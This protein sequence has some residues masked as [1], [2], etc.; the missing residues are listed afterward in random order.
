MASQ[1]W[2]RIGTPGS[3]RDVKVDKCK[4]DILSPPTANPEEQVSS[5]EALTQSVECGD[6]LPHVVVLL[7]VGLEH[8]GIHV[9]AQAEARHLPGVPHHREQVLAA[10]QI[11]LWGGRKVGVKL[12]AT[13]R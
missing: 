5:S 6:V 3:P 12:Q 11:H 10:A 1:G 8:N 9:V 7:R 2:W 13:S 4:A